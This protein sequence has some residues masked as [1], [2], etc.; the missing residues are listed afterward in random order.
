MLHPYEEKQKDKNN[1]D[2]WTRAKLYTG[3]V[4]STALSAL[5]EDN[6]SHEENAFR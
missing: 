3:S 5:N 2:T 4:E 6:K 1:M